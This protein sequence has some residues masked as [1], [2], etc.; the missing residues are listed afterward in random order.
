MEGDA[1]TTLLTAQA[2]G[3]VLSLDELGF[4]DPDNDISG[5]DTVDVICHYEE[6][7]RRLP[8][9][10]ELAGAVDKFLARPD[11]FGSNYEAL[12]EAFDKVKS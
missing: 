11:D 4:G 1:M 8:A 3:F 2:N 9:L 12:V 6:L 5:A 10:A 7:L